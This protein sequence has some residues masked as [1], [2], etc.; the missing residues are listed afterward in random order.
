[1]SGT[2]N[3]FVTP[4]ETGTADALVARLLASPGALDIIAGSASFTGSLQ[5]VSLFTAVD[6]TTS[7]DPATA[8]VAMG[9]GIL[10][11]SGDGAP[12]L[13]NTASS[14]SVNLNLP[15]DEQLRIVA[16]AAFGG[17]GPTY[18]ANILSFSFTASAPGFIS[19]DL[20]FG[21]DEYPEYANTSLGDVAAVFVN[22]VNYA[23]FN[24]DPAKP[25]SITTTNLS[26]FRNNS[27]APY[28]YGIEYDGI[29]PKL[30]L[31]APVVAGVN[32]VRIGVADTGDR[33]YD[34]GL[35]IG[36]FRPSDQQGG[37]VVVPVAI[38]NPEDPND[39]QPQYGDSPQLFLP[40]AGD[41]T[42]LGG[43]GND[44]IYGGTGHDSLNG[45]GGNDTIYG[46]A[47]N[48]TL[49]GGDGDDLLVG[50]P[51]RD[52]LTGDNFPYGGGTGG[53][54]RFAFTLTA[55]YGEQ[56]RAGISVSDIVPG[57][58]AADMIQDFKPA[59]GDWVQLRTQGVA[60][61][62]IYWYGLHGS[63]AMF[64]SFGEALPSVTF[65]AGYD[66][67]I[68]YGLPDTHGLLL[69]V[70]ENRN[71][72]LDPEDFAVRIMSGDSVALA[73]SL[74]IGGFAVVTKLGTHGDDAIFAEDRPEGVRG[75]LGDDTIYGGNAPGTFAGGPGNDHYVIRNR[76]QE[77]VERPGEGEDT[78][79]VGVGTL[80]SPYVIP[81]HVEI[82]RLFGG[83][84]GVIGSNSDEQL[85][86][87]PTLPSLVNGLGGHDVLWGGAGNNTLIGGEGDDIIRGGTGNETMIG[88]PG[89]DQYVVQAL[90]AVI[91]EAV[92]GGIDTVWVAVSSYMMAPNIEIGRLA[93]PGAT[94]LY[95][96]NSAEDLVGN[97]LE[98]SFLFGGGGDDVLWGFATADYMDGGA[99][100]DIFRGG[101]GADTMAGSIGNDQ[102]VIVDGTEVVVEN[103]GEGYDTAW[104]AAAGY[105]LASHV[106]R[107]NLAGDANWLMG[108][109]LDNV[110]VANP[111]HG[112]TLIGMEGNDL[113]FGSTFADT[114]NGGAGNDT[115]YSLGGA[116][117]FV[118]DIA[119]FGY[120]QINGFVLGQAKFDFRGSGYSFGD[121]FLNE[122]GGN[123]QI[124]VNGQAI[125]VFGVTGLTASDFIFA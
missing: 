2:T 3:D 50:G 98:A 79:W 53:A 58:T 125:L 111:L 38:P 73:N 34:S 60:P 114:F 12:P 94:T 57:M 118:Y 67:R 61:A 63:T 17:A 123:T 66:A 15:G 43:G 31:L 26:D 6:F 71:G 62:D 13:S 16:L 23:L 30:T 122:A 90:N 70:D 35:F 76:E 120:D 20:M 47:G 49:I 95:G 100:D 113:L 24:G 87:N 116:D 124:E 101:G 40:Q 104:V 74:N 112:S 42:V 115:F 119:L 75:L 65:P 59:Q 88:G 44:I 18:D 106:E 105:T 96:S 68:A 52:A 64:R 51:G 19:F 85:V 55:T 121:L 5:A 86:A 9:P 22:G 8:G 54:D 32:T 48:D 11:T 92:G 81:A 117:V 27:V 10:L 28:P 108:N 78:V 89:N 82:V 91:E 103:E 4:P 93:A 37:G 102:Y 83:A 39:V 7:G 72:Q 1:M 56:S 80:A 99:G 14:Y 110:L 25:L 77:V 109:N 29:T 41:D 97:P 36:N 21:S 84:T 69:V 107:G 45:A 33:I 46:E